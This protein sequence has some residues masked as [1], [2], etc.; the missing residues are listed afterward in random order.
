MAFS[1]G[2]DGLSQGG[3]TAADELEERRRTRRAKKWAE[4]SEAQGP[5]RRETVKGARGAISG[6]LGGM[7]QREEVDV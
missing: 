2:T 7:P 4:S 1:P 6:R 3:K 5:R